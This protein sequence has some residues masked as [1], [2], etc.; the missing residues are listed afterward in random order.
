MPRHVSFE[1]KNGFYAIE[2]WEFA[3]DLNKSLR[4]NL[5]DAGKVVLNELKQDVANSCVDFEP[6]STEIK[7]CLGENLGS[8][9]FD[10]S[11][12]F[13]GYILESNQVV[14]MNECAI[15]SL[16]AVIFKLTQLR[17]KVKPF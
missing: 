14:K 3:P 17:S 7:I 1:D 10:I 9:I 15:Q 5:I 8:L 16:D 2:N 11:E 13:E 6:N 12:A 4:Q